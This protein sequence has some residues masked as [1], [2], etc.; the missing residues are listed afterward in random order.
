[1]TDRR[2]DT[3]RQEWVY[4]ADWRTIDSAPKDGTRIL[5]WRKGLVRPLMVEYSQ[6][7][8]GSGW[9]DG[10]IHVSNLTHWM[11]LPEPPDD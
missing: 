5:A 3:E 8:D 10:L 4:P 11:H 2:W 7:V 6:A 1:M 9:F